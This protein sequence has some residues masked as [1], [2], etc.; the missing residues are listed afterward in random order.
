MAAANMDIS[1][2]ELNLGR[3][4][5]QVRHVGKIL[6]LP[7]LG[8]TAGKQFRYWTYDLHINFYIYNSQSGRLMQ[9]VGVGEC[10]RPPVQYLHLVLFMAIRQG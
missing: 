9:Y 7:L 5:H 3:R 10:T 6:N 4:K 8:K 1:R 2:R